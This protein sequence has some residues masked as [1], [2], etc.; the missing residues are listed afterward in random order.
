MWRGE[1]DPV[2]SDIE[3]PLKQHLE[4]EVCWLILEIIWRL[5]LNDICL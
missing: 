4:A 2:L 1:C 3:I 5:Y